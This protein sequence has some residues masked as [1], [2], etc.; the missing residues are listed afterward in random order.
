MRDRPMSAK[1]HESEETIP[2]NPS[3]G[4]AHYAPHG[5]VHCW[6]CGEEPEEH[7]CETCGERKGDH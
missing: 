7:A 6:T 1:A 4:H 3:D 5:M 2:A